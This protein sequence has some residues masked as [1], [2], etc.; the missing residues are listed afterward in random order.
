MKRRHCNVLP[1]IST[2]AAQATVSTLIATALVS[3]RA[4]MPKAAA[5]RQMAEDMRQ[6]GQREGG[7]S[8][9]DLQLLGWTAGQIA[10]FAD[11]ANVLAQ[12]LAGATL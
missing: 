12:S 5:I 11:G 6:A 2:L 7:C 8:D 4:G 9:R 3:P 10:E 1:A